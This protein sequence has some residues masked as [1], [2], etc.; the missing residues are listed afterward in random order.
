MASTGFDRAFEP[1]TFT[2]E[3]GHWIVIDPDAATITYD[4]KEKRTELGLGTYGQRFLPI[5]HTELTVGTTAY[6]FGCCALAVEG[7]TC[8]FNRM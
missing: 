3:P 1:A 4:G 2:L 5:E 6:S 7:G 8:P